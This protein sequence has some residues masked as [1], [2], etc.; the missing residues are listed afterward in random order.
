MN[1]RNITIAAA[2]AIFA[3]A[4]IA[5]TQQSDDTEAIATDTPEVTATESAQSPETTPAA[6]TADNANEI[7]TTENTVES[8]VET[9]SVN[10]AE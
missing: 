8:T 10:E 4:G 1:K 9:S 5:Y 3:V 2:A 7:N 6:N